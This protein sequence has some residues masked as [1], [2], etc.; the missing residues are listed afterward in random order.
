MKQF[1]LFIILIFIAYGSSAQNSEKQKAALDFVQSKSIDS[2]DLVYCEIIGTAKF[3]SSKLTIE[4]DFGQERAFK[5]KERSLVDGEGNPIIF[6]SMIDAINYMANYGWEFKQAYTV[7][8]SGSYNVYHFLL[9]KRV[10]K[11]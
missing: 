11:Q 8:Y 6:N 5:Y 3:L 10:P 2:T 1:I 9:S 4:I 7:T